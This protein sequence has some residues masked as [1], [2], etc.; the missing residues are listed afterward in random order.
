MLHTCSMKKKDGKL[1]I[2]PLDG[3]HVASES[4]L[5][6]D[7]STR[8]YDQLTFRM[9]PTALSTLTMATFKHP[10]HLQLNFVFKKIGTR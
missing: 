6:I 7:P 3:P 1:K 8:R 4:R 10:R 9:H 5:A 2:D